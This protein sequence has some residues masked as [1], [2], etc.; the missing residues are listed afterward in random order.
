MLENPKHFP[1][2]LNCASP[3]KTHEQTSHHHR[4]WSGRTGL[5]HSAFAAA[6]VRVK[7]SS[8]CRSS[9][10]ARRASK[11]TATN[12]ILGPT[13]FLY[14]R[15]LEEIF[16]AAGTTLQ[17]EVEMVRLDPQ[18]RIQFGAGGKLD[19]TP[20]IAAMESRSPRSRPRRAGF[21]R[22]SPRIAP[23]LKRMEPCLETPFHGWKDLLQARLLKMIP[24]LRPHQ[25]VDTYLKAL[26]QRRARP[27]LRFVFSRNI[28]ACPRSAARVCSAFSASWNT[29]TASGIRWWLRGGHAA[30]A[31]VAE[32]LGVKSAS[33][34]RWKKFLFTG[35]RAVVRTTNE[36]HRADALVVN[37][38]FARRWNGSCRTNCGVAGR[39]KSSRRKVFLLHVWR[40]ISAWKGS[41][42]C[43]ITR[44]TSPRIT[45]ATSTTSRTSTSSAPIRASMFRTPA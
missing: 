19:C 4:C 8:V 43:R 36:Y 9:A 17:S 16:R 34:N 18:Y 32:R 15:V 20:D 21:R 11:R 28:S 30:M 29:N 2:N 6:G 40:C 27:P 39:T 37:A 44:S 26:L 22:F 7:L 5:R 3:F 31:R 24:E 41:S 14:P 25:S 10:A 38:D 23:S 13:F 12:S 33:T 45:P 1:A 35:R 42:T